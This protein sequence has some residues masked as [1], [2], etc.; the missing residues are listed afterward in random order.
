MT[1]L[2]T[3]ANQ[4][5][6]EKLERK[7]ERYENLAE[8][9][10]AISSE[11]R[12][13]NLC[14]EKNT[15][16]PM[17]QPILIGHHSEKRHRKQLERIDRKLEKGFE[18]SKKAEYFEDKAKSVGTGGIASD[19]PA[20]L[21]KLKDKLLKLQQKRDLYKAFNK[22]AKKDRVKAIA[23]FGPMMSSDDIST[24]KFNETFSGWPLSNLSANIRSVQKRIEDIERMDAMELIEFSINDCDVKEEDGRI[25]LYFVNKPDFESRKAIKSLGMKWSRYNSC[26]TRKKTANTGLRFVAKLKIVLENINY[27]GA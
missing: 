14:G 6:D 18:A 2:R 24:L 17:G 25:N 8:K 20:A 9:N 23:K 15:G 16:I 12:I 10:N 5:Y 19:D 11:L 1:E 26:W 3:K 7:K 27:E 22:D 21:I 4:N 13:S